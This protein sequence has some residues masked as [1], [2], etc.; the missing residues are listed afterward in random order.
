MDYKIY[1]YT[2]K[3]CPYCTEL[4]QLLDNN[5]LPYE[6]TDVDENEEEWEEMGKTLNV[7]F[8]PTVLIVNDKLD[9]AKL[10]T[11]DTHFDEVSECFQQIIEEVR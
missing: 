7:E 4:K 2:T 5:L 6:A 10:L 11:P 9:T 1:L 3:D 8:V